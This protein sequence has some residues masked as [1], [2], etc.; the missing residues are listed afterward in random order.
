MTRIVPV[1]PRLD[2]VIVA[3]DE[4]PAKNTD[5]LACVAVRVKSGLT[6]MTITTEWTRAPLLPAT[7]IE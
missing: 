3:D 7:V 5:G 6:M 2:S 1:K 4:P